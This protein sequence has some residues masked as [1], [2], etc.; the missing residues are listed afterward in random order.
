MQQQTHSP[1]KDN[2]RHERG[3]DPAISVSFE[4]ADYSAVNWSLGGMLIE[5]YKGNLTS[6]ALFNIIEIGP[7][8]G[9]MTPVEVRA[10]VVRV[11]PVTFQLVVSF[12][13]IDNNAYR[14]LQGFMAQRIFSL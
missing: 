11:D 5:G 12:L 1:T 4:G 7:V 13:D 6:G 2:R 8:G 14:L 9:R 3:G 10:R